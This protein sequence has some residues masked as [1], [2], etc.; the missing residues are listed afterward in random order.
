MGSDEASWVLTGAGEGLKVL[1]S[2]RWVGSV[3]QMAPCRTPLGVS[4]CGSVK[5]HTTPVLH[6]LHISHTSVLHQSHIS[7][8]SVTHQS[9]FSH[10]SVPHQSHTSHTSVTH[11]RHIRS[12]S[13]AQKPL[14]PSWSTPL[15]QWPPPL[16]SEMSEKAVTILT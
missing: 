14:F 11:Q 4:Q 10:S 16:M 9:H 13:H 8:T 12:T 15:G 1:R 3:G 6:Q 7:H 2:R 5:R